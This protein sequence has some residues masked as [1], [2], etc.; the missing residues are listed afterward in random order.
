[1]LRR[2]NYGAWVDDDGKPSEDEEA[3][4]YIIKTARSVGVEVTDETAISVK[5]MARVLERYEMVY[6]QASK[7]LQ[8]RA[9]KLEE[10]LNWIEKTLKKRRIKRP[11]CPNK[12]NCGDCIHAESVWEDAVTFRG[13]KCRINAR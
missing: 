13:I 9:D 5:F 12:H 3:L 1:M 8:H 4:D 2:T 10:R 7:A 11:K 6:S